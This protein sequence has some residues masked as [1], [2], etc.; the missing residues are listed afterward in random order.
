LNA[1]GGGSYSWNTGATTSALHVSPTSNTTYT[2]I[3]SVGSCAD[4]ASATVVVNPSASVLVSGN[5]ILCAGDMTTLT[6]TGTGNYSWNT[7]A[8]TSVITAIPASTTT[9]VV[10]ALNANGCNDMDTAVVIVSPPPIAVAN[11]VTICSG[12]NATL[13]ASGGA[14]YSWSN[15]STSSVVQLTPGASST[16]TVIVSIG[17]C[18][19]TA[20]STVVVNPSAVA[21]AWNNITITAGTVTTLAASGGGT[22]TWS[23][24]MV[25]S[26]I[27]VAPFVTTIYCVTVSNG[28]SCTDTACVTVRVEPI[29]CA[30][31]SSEEAFALPS[32]FSP[33]NDG[34]NDRWRLLYVPLLAD[35]LAEFEVFVYNRWGEKIFE[36]TDINFSWDG[37]YKGRL[38]DTAVFG[39]YLEGILKDGTK[40]K[41]KGNVSLLR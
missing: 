28:T 4:T 22:Y 15:G 39:Y 35:C 29:N 18:L 40:I 20:V 26:V 37:T 3:V 31:V 32:A 41:K 30:P 23:N 21:T 2:V 14:V 17:S 1:S 25:D 11:N 33:N 24:D 8:T 38:E 12:E 34:Q 19:D 16:Y 9:Y 36:G 6:A 27:T 13:V 7:G 5:T 10:T